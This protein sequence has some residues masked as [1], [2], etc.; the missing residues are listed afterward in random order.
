[1]GA[2]SLSHKVWHE[3]NKRCNIEN[4][5]DKLKVGLGFEKMSQEEMDRN[6]AYI[7]LKVLSYNVLNWFRLALLDGK[8]SRAEVPTIRRK[9]LNVTGNV[10]GNGRYRHLKL[11]P[12]PWLEKVLK[13][14]IIE[15]ANKRVCYLW[16]LPGISNS[17]ATAH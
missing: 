14:S 10:V 8:Y 3:Y 9:I 12:N 13:I 17:G 2:N 7:W 1:M 15:F 11:A 16:E 6:K 4:K 5:I